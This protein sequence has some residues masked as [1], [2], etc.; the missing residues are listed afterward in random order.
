MCNMLISKKKVNT[1]FKFIVYNVV[2]SESSGK[3]TTDLI[4][5]RLQKHQ[6]QTNKSDLENIFA[7]W[8]ESGLIFENPNEYIINSMMMHF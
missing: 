3:F 4:Y 6:I 1:D 7:K 5:Q 2:F 8:V